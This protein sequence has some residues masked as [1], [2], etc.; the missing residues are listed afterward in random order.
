MAMG[1]TSPSNS[2]GSPTLSLKALNE[3]THKIAAASTSLGRRG[4]MTTSS[5]VDGGGAE[6]EGDAV[7]KEDMGVVALCF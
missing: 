1:G 4:R 3:A 5:L 6:A 7:E 2:G